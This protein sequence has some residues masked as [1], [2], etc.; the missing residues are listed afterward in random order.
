MQISSFSPASGLYPTSRNRSLEISN[1]ASHIN[2]VSRLKWWI[3]HLLVD[4]RPKSDSDA[5]A[6]P[7]NEDLGSVKSIRRASH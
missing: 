5:L 6:A 2:L 7:D 4:N 3:S 1:S